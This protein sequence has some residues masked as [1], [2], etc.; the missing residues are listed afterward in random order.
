MRR[1]RP[2]VSVL[3]AIVSDLTHF[4]RST[5]RVPQPAGGREF[6]FAKAARLL[7]RAQDQTAATHRRGS[8]EFGAV[9]PDIRLEERS[10]D[11]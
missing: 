3:F 10:D 1:L 6:V 7:W 2:L 11:R 8:V 4:L 9:V 5:L